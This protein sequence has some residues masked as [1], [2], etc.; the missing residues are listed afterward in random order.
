MSAWRV[1][2]AR[3]AVPLWQMVTVALAASSIM[4]M[5]LPTM[6]AAANHHGV[7]A[8]QILH[9]NAIRASS[10]SRRACRLLKPT[11]PTISAP[12]LAT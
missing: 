4:A 11:S 1:M 10:C 3:S 8:A 9:A 2:A 7:L 12:A 6:L 5:G